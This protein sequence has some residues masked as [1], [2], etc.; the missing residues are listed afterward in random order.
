MRVA[1]RDADQ[2]DPGT[3]RFARL[4]AG[5]L[6]HGDGYLPMSQTEVQRLLRGLSARLVDAVLAEELPDRDVYQVGAELV[7]A[8]LTDPSTLELTLQLLGT[9]LARCAGAS[10]PGLDDRLARIQGSLAAGYVTALRA[11]TLAE[12][13]RL[14]TAVLEARASVEQALRDSEARFRAVFAGAAIGI[15]IAGVDGRIAEV[16]QAFCDMLGYTAQEIREINVTD[17]VHPEDAPGMWELYAELIE[18]KHDSVRLEKRY[19]R[20]DGGVIWT[21]LAVSLIRDE[22]GRPR[23]TVAMIE[24][25]TDRYELQERL[26]FQAEHDPLTGLPNRTLF[27]A[28]LDEAFAAD[29]LG[30]HRIGVCYLDLD[31]FKVVNDTLGHEVGDRLLVK[32]AARLQRCVSETGHLVA[33]TGGD[34]F[35]ILVRDSTGPEAVVAVAERVLAELTRPV[36]VDGCRLSVSASIGIVEDETGNTSP[37]EVMRAADATLYWAKSDGRGRWAVFDPVR[38]ELEMARYALSAAMP[39]AI[40]RGEFVVEYQPIVRLSDG[41]LTGVEALVRWHHPELGVLLPDVFIGMAEETGLI[42]P[43]GR[44][45]LE[46]TCRRARAWQ[47]EFPEAGLV[48]SVNLAARQAREGTIVDD[49]ARV[50]A[51]TGLPADLLRLELTETAVMDPAGEPLP[52]LR[53]LSE[54]G[55]SIA[56]DDFGTGY[57]SLAYLRTLPIQN[58]KLA[59]LFVEGLRPAPGT[60]ADVASEADGPGADA[61]APGGEAV[62]PGERIVDALIRLAHALGLTVTAEAV[63][64]EDQ[65]ARL[66]AFGCDSGQGLRYA[67]ALA[68]DEITALLRA[69]CQAG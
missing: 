25:I 67:P 51:D 55:V 27:R 46:E 58:L 15:G 39:G 45:V 8:H 23:F 40:E 53:G 18:G 29:P 2:L 62:A 30:G 14:S 12:Q 44:W 35:V 22:A 6:T 10:R 24:D 3:V 56:I 31:G 50:L 21:D 4:W 5:A 65:A 17:L 41:A 26:R 1:P 32:V 33:R 54:L 61:G 16:N 63:E 48:V 20:K 47:L 7:G 66:R 36:Y 49:V 68:A 42:V 60:D 13:E 37:A 59:G 69:R 9:Q 28:A 38:N 52:A 43:L 11:L 64:T 34:E 57:S 19:F